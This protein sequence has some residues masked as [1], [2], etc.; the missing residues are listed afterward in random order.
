M[1]NLVLIFPE[2]KREL[3][4]KLIEES[5]KEAGEKQNEG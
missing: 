2:D 1:K 5:L 4:E 3:I